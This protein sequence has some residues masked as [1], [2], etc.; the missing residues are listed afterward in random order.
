MIICR[1]YWDLINPNNNPESS[2]KFARN[3]KSIFGTSCKSFAMDRTTASLS[4]A[5]FCPRS[6]SRTDILSTLW[7]RSWSS[8][9]IRSNW[10]EFQRNFKTRWTRSNYWRNESDQKVFDKNKLYIFIIYYIFFG[11]RKKRLLTVAATAILSSKFIKCS[12]MVEKI[13]EQKS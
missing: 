11:I 4:S 5:K 1:F 2:A 9:T 3:W 10:A 8:H 6:T 12:S 7:N 13:S